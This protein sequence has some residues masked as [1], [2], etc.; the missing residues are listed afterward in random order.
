VF[1]RIWCS[2]TERVGFPIDSAGS[3]KV[4]I[5]GGNGATHEKNTTS[6]CLNT[7]SL[8]LLD[9][10]SPTGA[11]QSN[12]NV[13]LSRQNRSRARLSTPVTFKSVILSASLCRPVKCKNVNGGLCSSPGVLGG[14]GGGGDVRGGEGSWFW[15]CWCSGSGGMGGGRPGP[16]P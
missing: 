10:G 3:I 15:I 11:V 7:A 2:R 6:T 12:A 9:S 5:R 14:R 13:D 1:S 8:A 4:G 16:G